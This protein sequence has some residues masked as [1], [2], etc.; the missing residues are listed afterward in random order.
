[1]A[2]VPHP[3]A[4]WADKCQGEWWWLRVGVAD[5]RWLTP[6]K[7]PSWLC[8]SRPLDDV[9]LS[10]CVCCSSISL[11]HTPTHYHLS[12]CSF[13]CV[14]VAFISCSHTRSLTI[15]SVIVLS[16]VCVLLLY[17]V[18]THAHP[19]SSQLLFFSMGE[20]CTKPVV[21]VRGIS[22]LIRVCPRPHA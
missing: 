5:T 9:C 4:K 14:C 17:H 12:Y 20:G 21:R 3:G 22:F 11:T 13:P 10:S 16:R 19:P 6:L 1:V 18:H 15:I 8:L 2:A 7:L